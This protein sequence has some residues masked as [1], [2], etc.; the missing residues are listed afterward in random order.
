MENIGALLPIIK[1]H[2][3]WG[4]YVRRCR[5]SWAR[6]QAGGPGRALPLVGRVRGSLL[7][8]LSVLAYGSNLSKATRTT[9]SGLAAGGV[10]PPICQPNWQSSQKIRYS[11]KLGAAIASYSMIQFP[12]KLLSRPQEG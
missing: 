4:A 10:P 11:S 3:A 2:C 1:I 12:P 8:P 5:M 9:L 6:T 7:Y